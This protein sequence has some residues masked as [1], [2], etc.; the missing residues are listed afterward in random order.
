MPRLLIK[1]LTR[2]ATTQYLYCRHYHDIGLKKICSQTGGM[3]INDSGNEKLT[4]KHNRLCWIIPFQFVKCS[5]SVLWQL[6]GA[7]GPGGHHHHHCHHHHHHPK[8]WCTILTPPSSPIGS[9]WLETISPFLIV[10]RYT[11]DFSTYTQH[12]WYNQLN[13][14]VQFKPI[15]FGKKTQW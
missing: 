13:W 15:H 1:K 7:A 5:W 9:S 10:T 8:V 11:A 2:E 14:T 6:P 3:W 12:I 4:K